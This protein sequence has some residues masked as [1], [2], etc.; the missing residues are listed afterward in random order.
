MIPRHG[1]FTMDMSINYIFH[2]KISHEF[3]I[4]L[5]GVQLVVIRDVNETFCKLVGIRSGL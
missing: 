2:E 1:M 3:D 5:I 4:S